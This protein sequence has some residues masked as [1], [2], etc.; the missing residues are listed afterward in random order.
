MICEPVFFMI[1]L[2]ALSFMKHIYFNFILY[3]HLNNVVAECQTRVKHAVLYYELSHRLLISP[4]I[5]EYLLSEV[6]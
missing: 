3:H 6:S 5:A 4:V 2:L 1:L